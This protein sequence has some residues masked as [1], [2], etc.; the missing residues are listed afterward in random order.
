MDREIAAE[1]VNNLDD[2]GYL[3]DE[4]VLPAVAAGHGV[5]MERVERVLKQVQR[6]DPVGIAARNLQECLL[7]QAE[8]YH[9]RDSLVTRILQEQMHNLEKRNYA[10]IMKE[11][12]AE[13]EEV[14]QALKIIEGFDPKPGRAYGDTTSQYITPDIYVYKVGDDYVISLNEDG[15]PKLNINSYYR[16]ALRNGGLKNQGEAKA[17]IQE[18]LRS[19]AWLIKSIHQRQRTIYRVMESILKYQR[20]FFDKGAEHLRPLVLRD[21][22][23][24]LKMHESTISRVTSNK[25][26][27]TPRGIFELKYF[28]NSSI[29]QGGGENI[30]SE[31]VKMMIK[32]LFDN[33]PADK[34]LSDQQIVEALG[35]ENIAIA[36]RTVAKYRDLMGILPSSK[37]RKSI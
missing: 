31:P 13:R 27:H 21:V 1:I 6:L 26:V 12:R 32:K 11:L 18:K 35:R 14:R 5:A 37:R 28:F 29:Q 15:L 22:A 19:A 2:S 36:R 3:R 33:E 30:A 7:A 16:E 10:G 9:V 24:D 34:P 4:G 20:D 25:F 17:Y 23:Q 8:H